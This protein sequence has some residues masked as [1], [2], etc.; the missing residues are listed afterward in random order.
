M[1]IQLNFQLNEFVWNLMAGSVPSARSK[2]ALITPHSFSR[3]IPPVYND[4]PCWVSITVRMLLKT[5]RPSGIRDKLASSGTVLN[6]REMK[7]LIDHMGEI[8]Q[9]WK[10]G[11]VCLSCGW[12]SLRSSSVLTADSR[13]G[14]WSEHGLQCRRLMTIQQN[15]LHFIHVSSEIC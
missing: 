15:I 12:R 11:C 7:R 6:Q 2:F 3:N 1:I 4:Y 13:W 14:T 8:E 9:S 10:S 5:Y